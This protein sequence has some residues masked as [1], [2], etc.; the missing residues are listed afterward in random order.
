LALGSFDGKVRLV[1]AYSW[2]LAFVLPLVHP[3]ELEAGFSGQAMQLTVECAATQ[4][5]LFGFTSAAQ[6]EGKGE[7]GEEFRHED[8]GGE[9]LGAPA[10]AGPRQKQLPPQLQAL[11]CGPLVPVRRTSGVEALPEE[12]VQEGAPEGS[13]SDSAAQTARQAATGSYFALRSQKTLPRAQAFIADSKRGLSST[14]GANKTIKKP[15]TAAN[16]VSTPAAPAAAPPSSHGSGFPA[17]GVSWVG[18]SSSGSLLA[19]R[20]ESHPRCVWV[21][22]PLSAQLVAVLVMLEPVTCAKWRPHIQKAHLTTASEGVSWGASTK[23]QE[24][25]QEQDVMAICTGN[26]RVYFWTA[27]TGATYADVAAT[28]AQ[29]PEDGADWAH[30][31]QH[32]T[33]SSLQ[34]TRDGRALVLRGKEAHCYCRVSLP[35]SLGLLRQQPGAAA[36]K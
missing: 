4:T 24:Q 31:R 21:W 12:G 28:S 30:G 13:G 7:E 20:E 19:A 11:R 14:G 35:T 33:A 5:S 36:T 25:D 18:W 10:I 29:G 3:R 1:S 9:T 22:R 32:F 23:D 34:W 6:G 27:A 17:M 8:G 2:Q 15:V 26:G 16:A